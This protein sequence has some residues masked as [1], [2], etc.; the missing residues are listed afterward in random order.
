[1]VEIWLPYGRSEIPVRVAEERLVDIL[2][3][4]SAS[5]PGE[6]LAEAEKLLLTNEKFQ[7]AASKAARPIIVLGSC[8]NQ[9]LATNLSQAILKHFTHTQGSVRI[10]CTHEATEPDSGVFTDVTVL[11]HTGKSASI[12]ITDFHGAFT[13]SID[14]EFVNSDLRI[15]IGELR[16]H[17][18]LE[19]SGLCDL[20]FP[21][22]AADPSRHLADRP[23]ITL[24]DLHKERVEIAKSFPNLFAL[25]FVLTTEMRPSRMAFG[26]IDDSLT[27]L[28]ASV[29]EVYSKPI[30][31][32]ADI[33]VMG[34]GGAPFDESLL[35]AVDVLPAGLNALKKDGTLILAAECGKGHGD[36]DFYGWS[37]EHKEPRYLETRLRHRFNYDGFKAS[38]LSRTLE[39]HR[40]CLV[41]TIPDHYV[42]NVFRMK[43]AT[44]VNAAL[45][46]AQRTQ[47]SDS[48]ITVIPD[49]SRVIPTQIETAKQ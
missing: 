27:T 48:T 39:S 32:R 30:T 11:K 34:A 29:K 23:G 26:A 5:S 45:H 46:N 14:A 49:A 40:V 1:M 35:E 43:S 12:P 15:L 9:Q 4:E 2:K 17:H 6:P 28:A 21:Y 41:S 25:G 33:V 16:P 18:F 44:T 22:L 24:A 36:T 47:G 20:V 42:E 19:Y 13:P 31:K 3:P 10:L 8:G 7:D 37:S 38:F